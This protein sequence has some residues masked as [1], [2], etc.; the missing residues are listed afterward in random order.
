[1]NQ[2]IVITHDLLY[3]SES[4]DDI[5]ECGPITKADAH[6]LFAAFPFVR[7]L[8]KRKANSDLM[9]P[10]MTLNNHF[11][12][13]VLA[14]WAE[15]PGAYV[16]WFPSET[17]YAEGV[18]DPREIDECI[19]LFFDGNTQVLVERISALSRK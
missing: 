1:M 17:A 5:E 10:T 18:K 16:L 9:F 7:E 6:R 8:E 15:E 4:P 13:S 14:I 3:A 2:Q 12:G 19:D 11:D